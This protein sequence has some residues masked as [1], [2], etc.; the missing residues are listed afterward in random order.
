MSDTEEEIEVLNFDD[1]DV[2]ELERRLDMAIVGG[3]TVDAWICGIDACGCN[4]NTCS[5]Q[6][7]ANCATACG[8]NCS[9]LCGADGCGSDCGTLG[10]GGPH[11]IP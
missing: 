1:L 3:A 5:T 9:G 2:E 10:C 4:S 6:C 7:A 8:A 11:Q